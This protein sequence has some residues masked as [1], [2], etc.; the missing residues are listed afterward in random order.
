M[1]MFQTYYLL[2]DTVFSAMRYNPIARSMA[3]LRTEEQNDEQILSALNHTGTKSL[4]ALNPFKTTDT[5]QQPNQSRM[6]LFDD[7]M[8]KTRI[9]LAL[10][11]DAITKLQKSF[12]FGDFYQRKDGI[13]RLSGKAEAFVS[14]WFGDLAYKQN[15]R[16][17]DVD[18]NGKIENDEWDALRGGFFSG[19]V[20]D[21]TTVIETEVAGYQKGGFYDTLNEALNA[22]I[23]SDVDS[24]G[25]LMRFG[26]FQS[27]ADAVQMI[28]DTISSG[29]NGKKIANKDLQQLTIEEFEKL[30]KDLQTRLKEQQLL[31]K[32]KDSNGELGNLTN[33]ELEILQNSHSLSQKDLK[34]LTKLDENEI[35][36]LQ[37]EWDSRAFATLGNLT[38]ISQEVWKQALANPKNQESQNR[39]LVAVIDEIALQIRNNAVQLFEWRA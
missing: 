4:A 6:V 24:N 2:Q 7:P 38:N 36:E 30:R 33:E 15:Y 21:S 19:G 23:L 9:S 25:H 5:A 39:E 27:V 28:D 37:D 34:T 20:Y 18:K 29:L 16:H 35:Q 8:S 1:A 14:G 31:Q 11:E 13:L 10:S 12:D 3:K 26:E 22:L 17:A 32:L